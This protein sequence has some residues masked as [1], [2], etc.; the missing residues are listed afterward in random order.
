[1]ERPHPRMV[2]PSREGTAVGASRLGGANVVS[3]LALRRARLGLVC[4]AHTRAGVANIALVAWG[5]GVMDKWFIGRVCLK[6][7][8][9][10]ALCNLL[11]ALTF[12]TPQPDYLGQV[13][14]YN[15]LFHGRERLPYGE[16]LT[17]AYNLSLN[18]IPAMLQSHTLAQP[19]SPHEFRVIL[20]GD[21][22]TWGWFLPPDETLAAQLNAQNLIA[23]DGRQMRFYN[24]GYPIMSLT[25]DLLLLDAAQAYDPDLFIWLV[26]LESFPRA[27]Q[28]FPPLVQANPHRL[29]PLVDGYALNL[30]LSQPANPPLFERTIWAQ[31][32]NLADLLRLQTT[33]A[34]WS[35]TRLDQDIPTEI[36]LRRTNFDPDYS[37]QTHPE[38]I[39]LTTN[40]LAFDVLSAGIQHAQVPV[41]LVNEPMFISN[42]RNSDIRY[43]AFYPRWAYD[44][45][46]AL[47][48][49]QATRQ[50]WH[51]LDLWDALPPQGF[52]DTPVHLTPNGTL[53]L[54]QKLTPTLTTTK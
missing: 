1:M 16:N 12:T 11:F 45:Y 15:S 18:N 52:T 41:L 35:A 9:L 51:Y 44:Q 19:K 3:H 17:T 33:G 23:E 26:T 34:S 13:S 6:A 27:K 7:I 40:D 38:P 48:A 29:Q 25:K 49:E 50:N 4:L 53:Q 28:T 43:N 32:R 54:A 5:W 2:S 37:W 22:S 42:G 21:S 14:L 36:P 20:L 8:L 46:R 31:R 30:T 10:F 47:L 39:T 24:L